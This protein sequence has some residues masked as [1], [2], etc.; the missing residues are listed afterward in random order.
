MGLRSGPYDLIRKVDNMDGEVRQLETRFG[1]ALG[2]L[3]ALVTLVV[4][5][6]AALL[7][8]SIKNDKGFDLPAITTGDVGVIIALVAL[9]AALAPVIGRV[10]LKTRAN[11]DRSG[12]SKV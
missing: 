7:V 1:I 6:L 10:L 9:V 12:R 3:I 5:A 8:V 11:K 4:T 2:L